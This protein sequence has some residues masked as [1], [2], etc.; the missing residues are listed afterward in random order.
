[1]VISSRVAGGDN[2]SQERHHVID[3]INVGNHTFLGIQNDRPESGWENQIIDNQWMEEGLK[4]VLMIDYLSIVE[5]D[6]VIHIVEA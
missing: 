1:M 2:S 4:E 3:G 5:T 6:K